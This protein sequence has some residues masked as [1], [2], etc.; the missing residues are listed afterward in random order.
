MFRTSFE[1]LATL[2]LK[3]IT[4]PMPSS[5]KEKHQMPTYINFFSNFTS[6]TSK[7]LEHCLGK[8][9]DGNTGITFV[10]TLFLPFTITIFPT[11]Y[12]Y[13]LLIRFSKTPSSGPRKVQHYRVLLFHSWINFFSFLF[14]LHFG[15]KPSSSLLPYFA[16]KKENAGDYFPRLSKHNMVLYLTWHKTYQLLKSDVYFWSLR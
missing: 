1:I 5:T 4:L 3:S 6:T 10:F 16:P 8:R 9:L 11:L 7:R 15:T 12:I 2:V 13:I 14:L